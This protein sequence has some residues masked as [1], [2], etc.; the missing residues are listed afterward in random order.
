MKKEFTYKCECC[1]RVF[2]IDKDLML[3]PFCS[4]EKIETKPLKGVLKVQLPFGLMGSK[5]TNDGFD[6]FDYLP[7]EK[8]FFPKLPVGNTPLI[9]A[10]NIQKE[11]G[12]EKIFLKYDGT[13]PTG[14][15]KDRASFLVSAFAKKY[16]KN[17]IVVASTG[18]AASS[19]SGI[20]AASEQKV[21][22]LMP[23]SAPKAKIIQCLQY[24]A[25]V[26]PIKGNYDKA[27]ELSIKL[28][29]ESGFLNR[30]TAFNP[31]TIEG[32]KTVSFEL[33]SQLNGRKIDY[34]FIPVGDGV[35]LDGIIKGFLD[36]L[37]L[38]LINFIPK[39]IGV[40]AKGSSFI[41]NAF[42]NNKFNVGSKA[43]TIADSISVDVAC[44]AFS[45][46]RNLKNV[47]GEILL[48]SDKEILTAQHYIS[49]KSGIFSEPSSAAAF[50]GF[51]KMKEE[52]PEDKNYIILLTGSGL[53]DIDS[54]SK[55]IKLPKSFE[56]DLNLIMKKLKIS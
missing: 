45:A 26:I 15:F 44:N 30:N 24:G 21:Y 1:G 23:D 16:K 35:I 33:Y 38:G 3:C 46:V 28:S 49:K 37:Y 42:Y 48:V 31:M 47:N 14:S 41:F 22:V 8:E 5:K 9:E 11:L 29:S 7:V 53:K 50:A 40:Q 36:M 43:K 20:A 10:V 32:K 25:V 13:N 18:N 6:I 19:M 27:F 39:I 52:L 51:L 12:F 54:A 17:E 55:G 4:H 34:V 2:E 56:P